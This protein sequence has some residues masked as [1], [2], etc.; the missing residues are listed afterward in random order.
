MKQQKTEE[1]HSFVRCVNAP[2]Q[3]QI[4]YYQKIN[5]FSNQPNKQAIEIKFIGNRL[6]FKFQFQND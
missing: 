6:N 5:E 4:F 3:W 2:L 1:N